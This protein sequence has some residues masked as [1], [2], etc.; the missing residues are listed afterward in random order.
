[1]YDNLPARHIRWEIVTLL[2]LLLGNA[3]KY[4]NST[5][6]YLLGH[7]WQSDDMFTPEQLKVLCGIVIAF[8]VVGKVLLGLVC[9]RWVLSREIFFGTNIGTLVL[10][11]LSTNTIY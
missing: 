2:V 5:H 6:F 8:C 11:T 4:F 7:I 3:G 1:M 9:D 10:L